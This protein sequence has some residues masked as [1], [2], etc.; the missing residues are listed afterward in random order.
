MVSEPCTTCGDETAAG[1]PRF[2]DRHRV[3]RAN[4]STVF[5]CAE[6]ARR[7][8]SHVARQ[9]SDEELRRFVRSGSLAMIAGMPG[10]H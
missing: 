9:L 10:A 2:T 3:Q 4:G 6:C 7:L 5:L 1:S 8:S